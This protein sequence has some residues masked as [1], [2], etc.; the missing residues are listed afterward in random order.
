MLSSISP[1]LCGLLEAGLT[2]Y[3]RSDKG[4]IL[5]TYRSPSLHSIS[6]IQ[7][8]FGGIAHRLKGT[9]YLAL[10][11]EQVASIAQ[12]LLPLNT[13]FSPIYRTVLAIQT[14]K[15]SRDRS[16]CST[17]PTYRATLASLVSTLRATIPDSIPTCDAYQS[18]LTAAGRRDTPTDTPP[19]LVW[20]R[21][22]QE[23]AAEEDAKRT[24]RVRQRLE[25]REAA[26]R[27]RVE[28]RARQEA[29]RRALAT[30]K[31]EREETERNA[32]RERKAA[33][34][35][36]EASRRKQERLARQQQEDEEIRLRRRTCGH[37]Q[38]VKPLDQFNRNQSHRSGYQPYCK[39]CVY[40]HYT[41]PGRQQTLQRCKAWQAANPET[42]RRSCAKQNAKPIN[43]LR[44]AIRSRMKR[45]LQHPLPSDQHV[46]YVGASMR[47]LRAYIETL[48]SDGM[49]W[50]TH[51]N[52]VN[53]WVIDHIV[54]VSSFDLS[55]EQHLYWCWNYRNLR[56]LWVRDNGIKSD[57]IAGVSVRQLRTTGQSERLH[58]LVGTELERLGIT[59]KATYL[60]SVAPI[61]ST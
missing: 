6:S 29:G 19:S 7:Q 3:Y 31:R 41:K 34:K 58:D 51:G 36:E 57:L 12:A 48:W 30:Q 39:Q 59:T 23:V 25:A 32:R 27:E 60:T 15:A 40:E 33:A 47:D 20:A 5:G 17:D 9:T 28:T 26:I 43:R 2:I 46:A 21:S 38:T 4:R 35:A 1:Y 42:F 16:R 45:D 37:C 61:P 22:R 8:T 44:K 54:S 11:T 55:N 13:P 24:T 10:N 14:H 52:G 53:Q 50:A 49:T 56:P 18:G